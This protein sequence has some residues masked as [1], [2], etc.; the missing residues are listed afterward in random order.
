M[1]E[2]KDYVKN[3]KNLEDC[4]CWQNKKRDRLKADTLEMEKQRR[5]HSHLS[6]LLKLPI[7]A[8]E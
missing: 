5:F 2:Q 4:K 1:F 6:L 3:R 8:A 7:L